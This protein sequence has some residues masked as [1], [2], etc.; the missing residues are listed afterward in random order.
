[1]PCSDVTEVLTLTLDPEDRLTHYS[2]IK[3]TCGGGVGNPSLLRKWIENRPAEE[4]LSTTPDVVLSEFPTPSD[5][6]EFL[7]IKHLLAVQSG[8]QA[9]LGTAQSTPDSICAIETVEHGPKGV[10]MM[11][12]I[13]V[14]VLT[15]A[16]TACGGCG[17]CGTDSQH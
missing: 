3:L 12:L 15:Q 5:T 6:W 16:I 1:M 14:D 17:T 10:R 9:L 7:T 13:K 8:L 11:A 4:I 2:L